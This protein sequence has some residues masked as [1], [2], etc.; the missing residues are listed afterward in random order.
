MWSRAVPA[1]LLAA[2]LL[3]LGLALASCPSDWPI[4]DDT[5]GLPGDDDSASGDE[6]R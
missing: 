5:S 3:C 4:D 2:G 1:A 6:G